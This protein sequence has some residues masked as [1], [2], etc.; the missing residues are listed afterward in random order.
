MILSEKHE[1]KELIEKILLVLGLD[2][3][4][5]EILEKCE[6]ELQA[7]AALNFVKDSIRY[8][9]FQTRWQIAEFV[10]LKKDV[11]LDDYLPFLLEDQDQYVQRRVL[12]AM[13][14]RTP[15]LATECACRRITD[16]DFMM[17]LIS[18]R[19]LA[20]LVSSR[21]I[22]ALELL[23]G[24]PHPLVRQEVKSMNQKIGTRI[25]E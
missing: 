9:F 18:L 1:H 24:D 5:G 19:I 14:E 22:E 23:S 25:T 8:P 6:Q 21:L 15:S 4:D 16:D 12:L 2:H 3:E 17:R 20:E 10:R 11:V 7:D 13:A